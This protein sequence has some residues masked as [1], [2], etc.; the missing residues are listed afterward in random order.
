[1][2]AAFK[3]ARSDRSIHVLHVSLNIMS[4]VDAGPAEVEAGWPA[5]HKFGRWLL[6]GGKESEQASASVQPLLLHR[7]CRRQCH[8]HR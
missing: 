1:V 8:R 6:N 3:E 4:I 7:R 2:V 5:I